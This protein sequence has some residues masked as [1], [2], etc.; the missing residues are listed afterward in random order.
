VSAR[1]VLSL[2]ALAALA[3]AAAS[4]VG[5]A[6]L[7]PER[8]WRLLE[9]L[10]A[11]EAKRRERAEAQLVRAADLSVAAALVEHV[12][13]TPPARPHAVRVLSAL[14]GVDHG[15]DYK[16][17]LEEIGRREDI[18]PKPGYVAFKARLYSKIDPAFAEFLDEAAPRTIR[19]EEIVWGGVK[20]DGI[21][22]LVNPDFVPAEEAAYLEDTER[23][24]GVSLG[25]DARAYPLRI[26][27]W[28]EMANDVVGGR[29][30]SLSYCTLCGSAILFDGTAAP[31]EVYT[32]GS[33]GLLYRSNKLMYDHQTN[34]LWSNLSGEPVLGPLVG[35]GK[36]LRILPL[37][38][39]SWG[40]WRERHPETR[41]LS[42]A[43]G[44]RRDYRPG[45]AY[46]KYFA[47][48]DPMF[49]VWKRAPEGE[50]LA[51][52]A[53][54]WAVQL[55]DGR[56]KA[57]PLDELLRRPILH[58]EVRGTPV[59]LLTDPESESVRVYETGGRRF[60]PDG[61][62]GLVD[63]ATGQAFEVGEEALRAEDGTRLGRLGG[64]RAYWFGWYAFFPGTEL[65]RPGDED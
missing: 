17:W 62:G 44:Y 42:L 8:A 30:V 23:V 64:H 60:R 38:V 58:D 10:G 25:G 35:R 7:K 49:P 40:E 16:A 14:L 65:Y 47:S 5:A 21:P 18:R 45:A 34:S 56:R 54:L 3:G 27:D 24:F 31:G 63:E 4:G 11:D 53:W 2:A 13:F 1:H 22:A 29:S 46:G 57:Y 50:G 55:E 51:P 41:V 52:K 12:F 9:D 36:R 48:P 6:E 39:T 32:F 15:S 61:A 43:T 59:L 26:L 33:S 28:H 37:S 20:K 19:P